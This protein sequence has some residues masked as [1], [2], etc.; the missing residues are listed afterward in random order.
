[1]SDRCALISAAYPGEIRAQCG[2]FLPD[3][4]PVDR[5]YIAS[6]ID[7]VGIGPDKHAGYFFN[8]AEVLAE[9]YDDFLRCA[10]NSGYDL[11][12]F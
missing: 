5:Y 2:V 8:K 6:D 12:N 11:A 10:D 3:D 1:M 7:G 4:E 9:R